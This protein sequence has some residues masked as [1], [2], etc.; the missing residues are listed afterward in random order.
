MTT[1]TIILFIVLCA[2]ISYI[3]IKKQPI[4]WNGGVMVLMGDDSL[5]PI[6]FSESTFV[7][8]DEWEIKGF[9]LPGALRHSLPEVQLGAEK[10]VY[11]RYV[12]KDGGVYVM[13]SECL[14]AEN[15]R[16]SFVLAITSS[17]PWKGQPEKNRNGWNRYYKHITFEFN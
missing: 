2:C 3:V 13:L 1:I 9:F 5:A 11:Y 8:N 16:S 10:Y 6:D 12:E 15:V 14:N 4:P 17:S 7:L